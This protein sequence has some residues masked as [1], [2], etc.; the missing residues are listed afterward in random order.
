M[1]ILKK[2]EFH[3]ISLW[4]HDWMSRIWWSSTPAQVVNILDKTPDKD[5]ILNWIKYEWWKSLIS[6]ACSQH[7]H[8]N[9]RLIYQEAVKDFN[10]RI[11]ISYKLPSNPEGFYEIIFWEKPKYKD[12]IFHEIFNALF[13]TEYVDFY[14]KKEE[15]IDW[16]I[17]LDEKGKT[18]KDYIAIGVKCKFWDEWIQTVK[19]INASQRALGRWLI[20]TTLYQLKLQ[21][22]I[23]LKKELETEIKNVQIWNHLEEDEP[24]SNNW[25]NKKYESQKNTWLR[26][27]RTQ[28]DNIIRHTN[29]LSGES[30]TRREYTDE[31]KEEIEQ[32]FIND[33]ARG[34]IWKEIFLES[35]LNWITGNDV[36]WKQKI[37]MRRWA[38]L[39]SQI[40]ILQTLYPKWPVH[41]YISYFIR[42]IAS[43]GV[44]PGVFISEYIIFDIDSSENIRVHLHPIFFEHIG[45]ETLDDIC[46]DIRTKIDTLSETM[47]GKYAR[48][49]TPYTLRVESL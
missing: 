27:W 29:V 49:Y 38:V 2:D 5:Q 16:Y 31:E 17:T 36:K 40:K 37:Y 8:S 45:W 46:D 11:N 32:L 24:Q 3:E 20:K 18:G 19:D 26:Y 23:P 44:P 42:A 21:M 4:S 33:I 15:F 14:M 13:P 41:L 34:K 48:N 9:R 10:R 22:P 39:D 30:W 12:T 7:W 25:L 35:F 43:M 1:S 47:T 6:R 28:N